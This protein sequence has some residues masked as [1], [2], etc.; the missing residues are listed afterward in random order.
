ML[1]S[2]SLFSGA[3]AHQADG[4]DGSKPDAASAEQPGTEYRLRG[5][6]LAS[7]TID[8]KMNL[9]SGNHGVRTVT[10]SNMDV[11]VNVRVFKRCEEESR[12][13]EGEARSVECK[14]S[15]DG[16]FSHEEVDGATFVAFN[17]DYNA[18]RHHPPK[19]N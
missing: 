1:C 11:S 19:N 17:A 7:P 5:R 15:F 14:Q 13:R 4:D 12:G 3:Y 9:K 10:S 8:D 18:P 2:V 16:R 6:K